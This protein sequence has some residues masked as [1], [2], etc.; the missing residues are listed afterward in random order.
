MIVQMSHFRLLALKQDKDR[1]LEQLQRFEHVH[2]KDLPQPENEEFLTKLPEEDVE[3]LVQQRNTIR[4]LIAEIEQ[5]EKKNRQLVDRSKRRQSIL[6]SINVS[7]MT[8]EELERRAKE[9]DIVALLASLDTVEEAPARGKK[10][11]VL[12]KIIPWETGKLRDEELVEIRDGRAVL[13]TVAQEDAD[14]FAEELRSSGKMYAIVSREIDG[15]ILFVIKPVEELREHLDILVE[16]Y[17]LKRR[18]VGGVRMSWEIMDFRR[19]IDEMISRQKRTDGSLARMAD[20]KD[21]LQIYAEYL[22]NLLLRHEEEKKFLQTESALLIEGWI[23]T[24]QEQAFRQTIE[25]AGGAPYCLNVE[26]APKDSGEVP[27]RL[28]NNRIVRPFESLTQMYSMP[29]YNEIDPTPLFT[30]F[31]LLFYGMMLADVGYGLIILLATGLILKC[32]DLKE[33]LAN[34]L[35][36]LFY[37][38]FPVI[39]WGFIYGSFFCGIIPLPGLINPHSEYTRVLIMALIFGFVHLLMG[40]AIKAYLHI[41]DGNLLYALFD[42]GFWYMALTGLALVLVQ[43]FVPAL[44]AIPTNVIWGVAI[45][46]M[47]G[48][49]FTNGRD[50]LTPVGKGA[51]GLYSLYGL[52]NY[53]GDVISY[54][55]LMALGL[56]GGSIGLAINM[57]VRMLQGGGIAGIIV[58]VPIFAGIHLFNLFISG[59]SS[60]VH[61]ARLTYVEFFGKFYVGSGVSFAPFRAKMT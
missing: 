50:A 6:R 35:R 17:R 52:T 15:S 46:G 56:A 13:G 25:E 2:F 41:R 18:S 3:T 49:V 27:V 42:V 48:I 61:A 30:P 28:K 44:A 45:V 1:L 7:T 58:S 47:V 11:K 5:H 14:A 60:Y 26:E 37:L 19:T 55:R 12:Y 9:I 43:G 38:S 22:E 34:M 16:K 8:F 51:S 20:Y 31:Y 23:P 53:I 59:L 39:G 33:G 40:L 57:I 29:K 36:F 10:T 4:G 32:F 54:S 21:S 24:A